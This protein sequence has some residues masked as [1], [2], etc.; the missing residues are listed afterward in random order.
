MA[1]QTSVAQLQQV[2]A[3]QS[4]PSGT[5]GGEQA[6]PFAKT[7]AA[8]ANPIYRSVAMKKPSLP[9]AAYSS[10]LGRN[11]TLPQKPSQTSK[12]ARAS[13]TATEHVLQYRVRRQVK[14]GGHGVQYGE[15]NANANTDGPVQNRRK[16]AQNVQTLKTTE[17]KEKIM[18]M[19]RAQT[20]QLM[21]EKSARWVPLA[22]TG[23]P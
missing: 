10:G 21:S 20:K 12:P 8:P 14:E 1:Y 6:P 18:A 15:V 5:A 13:S 7:K 23:Q 4:P 2:T 16:M 9:A 11:Q 17:H 3:P 22:G 19:V